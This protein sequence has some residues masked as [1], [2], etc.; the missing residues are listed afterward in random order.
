MASTLPSRPSC[1]APTAHG[2]P[3]TLIFAGALYGDHTAEALVAA[4]ARPEVHG[5]VRLEL[6][7]AIDPRTRRALDAAKVDATVA[8]DQLGEALSSACSQPTSPW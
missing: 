6:V 5:R 4:L 7:G 8:P 3:A 2:S 1:R